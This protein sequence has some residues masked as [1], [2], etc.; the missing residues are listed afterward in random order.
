L[1]WHKVNVYLKYKFA[2]IYLC[3]C[4]IANQIS[5]EVSNG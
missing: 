2:I 1:I 5:N 3:Y 4:S